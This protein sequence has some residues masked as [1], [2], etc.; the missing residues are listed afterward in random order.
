MK[1]FT[2]I[3]IIVFSLVAV[4]QLTRFVLGWEVSVNGVALPVWGSGIAFV[5]SGGLAV[6]LWRENRSSH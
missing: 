2:V 4:L 5:V 3:S 6:M 1:P